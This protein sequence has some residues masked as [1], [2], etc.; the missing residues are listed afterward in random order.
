MFNVV[1]KPVGLKQQS[2]LASE[3]GQ[4]EIRATPT[5]VTAAGLVRVRDNDD[6]CMTHSLCEGAVGCGEWT[7]PSKIPFSGW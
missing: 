2:V 1:A 6:S 3:A 7:S 5:V 4:K